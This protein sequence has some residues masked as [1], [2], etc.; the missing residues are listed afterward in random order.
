MF[1][2][3]L[4]QYT[5]HHTTATSPK[6]PISSPVH[7]TTTPGAPSGGSSD[8]PVARL[9]R[10]SNTNYCASQSS[11]RTTVATGPRT[12]SVGSGVG[13][14]G[15]FQQMVDGPSA[16]MSFFYGFR[17]RTIS[18][19]LR[20]LVSE[21]LKPLHCSLTPLATDTS[22]CGHIDRGDGWVK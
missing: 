5:T 20:S 19:N 1:T 14:V 10:P 18:P 9:A 8:R 4:V 12:F 7:V 11:G 13:S 15:R 2:N 3:P 22:Q 16:W 21:A 6:K 17:G